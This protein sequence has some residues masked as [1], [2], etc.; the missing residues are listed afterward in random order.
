MPLHVD[1]VP[2]DT[3]KLRFVIDYID[4]C[5]LSA[6]HNVVRPVTVLCHE[7]FTRLCIVDVVTGDV[8]NAWY[9]GF[10]HSECADEIMYDYSE[11]DFEGTLCDY[12]ACVMFP[13]A[14]DSA[15]ERYIKKND[16]RLTATVGEI[17]SCR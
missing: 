17:L 15:S 1:S 8:I 16:V 11:L 3:F 6:T 4:D 9:V 5:G 10:G 14:H 2:G 12:P 13:E 7:Q